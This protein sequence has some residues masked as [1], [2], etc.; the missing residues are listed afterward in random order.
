VRST[1]IVVVVVN[2]LV[3]VTLILTS[4]WALSKGLISPGFWFITVGASLFVIATP[5]YK[6]TDGK[7]VPDK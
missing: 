7:D 6:E 1:F 3:A 5:T 4:T 2:A